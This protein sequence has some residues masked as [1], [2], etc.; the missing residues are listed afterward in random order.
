MT[1]PT[2][3]ARRKALLRS[4]ELGG[5]GLGGR[6]VQVYAAKGK[7]H[8]CRLGR[9]RREALGDGVDGGHPETEYD[10]L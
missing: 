1:W 7:G 8:D 9:R 10:E 2:T 3:F 4:V 5:T 6:G